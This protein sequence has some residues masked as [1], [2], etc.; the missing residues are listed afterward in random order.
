MSLVDSS[1]AV[2]TLLQSLTIPIKVSRTE[3]VR[4]CAQDMPMVASI[5]GHPT[6]VS[7]DSSNG[8]DR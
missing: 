6:L 1:V 7:D 8:D 4:L 3:P 5:K 2:V